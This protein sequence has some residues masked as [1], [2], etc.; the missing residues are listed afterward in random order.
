MFECP[1]RAWPGIAEAYRKNQVLF[2][3]EST[4][5]AYL[6]NDLSAGPQSPPRISVLDASGLSP[7][8]L[9]FYNYETFHGHPT[10]GVAIDRLERMDDDARERGR[11]RASWP[12]QLVLLT[13]HEGFHFIA[14]A[15]WPMAALG[16]RSTPYPQETA[17]R[18]LRNALLNA[19]A[20]ALRTQST[21]F[22][23]AAFWQA[24]LKAEHPAML[25]EAA[26]FDVAE[27]TAQYAEIVMAALAVGGCQQSDAAL[28]TLIQNNVGGFLMLD[29][30]DPGSEFYQIGSLAGLLLRRG[31][32]IGWELAVQNQQM[33]P[34]EVLLAAASPAPQADDPARLMAAAS[35][36][37]DSNAL[38]AAAIDPVLDA[39]KSPASYR[40]ALSQ[41][42]I[43]GAFELQRFITLSREPGK[44]EAMIGVSGLLT[45]PGSGTQIR[46]NGATVPVGWP[47]P[48]SPAPAAYF[49][50]TVP[51]SAL[52]TSGG[53]HSSADAKISFTD[54][55]ASV[56][57][58]AQGL[59]W[60]CP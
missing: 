59:E 23:A 31:G 39:L 24:R 5:K 6:L 2:V 4:G 3:S 41:A 7:A 43:A 36:V 44:P 50:A 48:C 45:H 22:A 46:L 11:P 53:K 30:F 21:D 13:L 9:Q 51:K 20:Q 38:L 54:L 27:G 57:A 47:T 32:Q 8:W 18:Y 55:P 14:Q 25:M 37:N 34:A 49:V 28:L 17:P 10:L 15:S 12:D 40:L 60:L 35:Y 19:L 58:D 33:P 29:T 42:W 56:T 1:D 16:S 52:T 26:A